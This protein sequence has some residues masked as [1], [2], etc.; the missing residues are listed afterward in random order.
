VIITVSG[1]VA[2]QSPD[3]IR[4]AV[5]AAIIRWA[6]EAVLLDVADVSLLEAATI[7]ELL[8]AHQ[9]GAWGGI[10]VTLINVG[11]F[12]VSQLREAGLANLLC[13][14]LPDPGD[15]AVAPEPPP[16]PPA[17]ARAD[18]RWEVNGE[19]EPGRV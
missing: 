7:S 18:L 15:G 2:Y 1:V 5:R 12:P 14:D 10:P 11:A 16:S 13:P 8:A 3:K 6:P 4:G 17:G 19:A 9:I